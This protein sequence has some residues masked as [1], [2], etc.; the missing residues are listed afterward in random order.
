MACVGPDHLRL[1]CSCHLGLRLGHPFGS[2]FTCCLDRKVLLACLLGR[3]LA[4]LGRGLHHLG[5][6]NLSGDFGCSGGS[7]SSFPLRQLLVYPDPRHSASSCLLLAASLHSLLQLFPSCLHPCLVPSSCRP[8]L[9]SVLAFRVQKSCSG[10][11]LL[12]PPHRSWR[13]TS[14]H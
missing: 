9:H 12:V 11:F 10:C 5:L 6:M 8:C 7:D 2:N 1:A 3:L 4:L 14:V 13:S